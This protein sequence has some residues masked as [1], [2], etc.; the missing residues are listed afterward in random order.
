MTLKRMTR[1]ALIASLCIISRYI[2]GA[3]PNV[4]PITAIFFVMAFD[5]GFL[6]AF[7][8]MVICMLVS[9]FVFG[10][11]IWIYLQVITYTLILGIWWLYK[12]LLTKLLCFDIMKT[13]VLQALVAGAL[14]F[15][16]GFM[17]DFMSALLFHLPWWGYMINGFVFNC[18]HA[19]STV[20]FY[21]II[22]KIFRRFE[23]EKNL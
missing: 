13:M 19:I 3:F 2:F 1:I 23:N 9:S 4:K 20:L 6:D 22:F 14:A 15:L 18:A 16:Y 12:I 11:G 5:F 8:T 10:M 21:P 17:I 7:I